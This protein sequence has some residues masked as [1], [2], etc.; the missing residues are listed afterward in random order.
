[1]FKINRFY[2]QFLMQSYPNPEDKLIMLEKRFPEFLALSVDRRVGSS[3]SESET[4]G[5]LLF[6]PCELLFV[7]GNFFYFDI[8]RCIMTFSK[9]H[10][11]FFVVPCK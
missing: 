1:M 6:L 7:I 3:Q 5:S 9:C 2:H 4:K 10:S 11:V 8:L